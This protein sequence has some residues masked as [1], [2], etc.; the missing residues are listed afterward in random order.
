MSVASDATIRLWDAV[1]FR[2]VYERR[3]LGSGSRG[4]SLTFSPDGKWLAVWEERGKGQVWNVRGHE[5]VL[6]SCSQHAMKC[7]AAVAFDEGCERLAIMGSVS[8]Y[9]ISIRTLETWDE[10]V[11]LDRRSSRIPKL[12]TVLPEEGEQDTHVSFNIHET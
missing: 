11:H 7:C 9:V 6:L 10:T 2:D 3:H 8:P 12:L 1:T 5:L 4:V